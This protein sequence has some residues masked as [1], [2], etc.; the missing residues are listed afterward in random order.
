MH[1]DFFGKLEA[2]A[3]ARSVF[4]DWYFSLA[5]GTELFALVARMCAWTKEMGY[6]AYVEWELSSLS[7]R[8]RYIGPFAM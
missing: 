6:F 7:T 3:D 4:L 5:Y 2:L 1:V 8:R